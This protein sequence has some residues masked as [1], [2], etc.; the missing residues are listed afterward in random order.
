MAHFKVGQRIDFKKNYILNGCTGVIKKVA[1]E[2]GM[3]LVVFD[4]PKYE[5]SWLFTD[6]MICITKK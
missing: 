5:W 1:P 4:K 3:A 6:N 2:I